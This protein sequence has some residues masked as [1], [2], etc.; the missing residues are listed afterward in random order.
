MHT[1]FALTL[2]LACGEKGAVIETDSDATT[3]ET[4]SGD[5]AAG[6]SGETAADDTGTTGDDTG[7]LPTDT[8]WTSTGTT[9]ATWTEPQ[10]AGASVRLHDTIESLVYVSW[11]QLAPATV[12]VEYSFDDGEWHS[13][14]PVAV[15]SEAVEQLVLGVPYDTAFTWQ[16]VNDFGEGGLSG[17][18][19]TSTTG[20]LPVGLPPTEVVS[21]DEALWYPEGRYLYTSINEDDGGWTGGTY[22]KFI[23]DRQGRVVWAMETANENWTIWVEVSYDGEDLMWDDASE[24][25]FAS[26]EVSRVHRMK[27]DGTIVA[28]YETEGLHHAWDELSDGTIVWGARIDS[29]EEWLIA[30][31]TDGSEETLWKCSEFEIE[32]LGHTG[33]SC[34]SNSWWWHEPSD[35]YLVSFPASSGDTQNTVAHLDSDGAT[36]SAWGGIGGIGGWTFEPESSTFDYQHGV[37]FTGDDTLL[38]STQL[39]PANPYYDRSNDVLAVREYELDYESQVLRQIWHFGED[40]GIPGNYAGEAHRLPNGNTLHNFGT[41]ARTREITPDGQLVWD[42]KWPDGNLEGRGRLQGRS[43][44]LE[45]LYDFAP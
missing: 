16:I 8:S 42:I 7:T 6:D 29:N 40:L 22:W 3:D 27:I 13:T 26:S 43:V 21:G 34:H 41:G 9:G 15:E 23:I 17:G 31:H 39:T 25:N 36:L 19:S 1:I 37:T 32:Q 10:I 45:D 44:F 33:R 18:A 5:T 2:L 38:V 12:W 35:T 30:R 4:T 20:A 11:E 14:P 28:S 24:W